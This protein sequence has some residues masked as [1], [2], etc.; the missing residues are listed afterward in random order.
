MVMMGFPPLRHFMPDLFYKG[1]ALKKAV[2]LAIDKNSV[3][4]HVQEGNANYVLNI[5]A[6]EYQ[7]Y[8]AKAKAREE[9]V[10]NPLKPRFETMSSLWRLT[11]TSDR[12]VIF[13]GYVQGRGV[14]KRD[15]V[16]DLIQNGL[17]AITGQSK[18]PASP[19]SV[20]DPAACN[21]PGIEPWTDK[22]SQNWSRLLSGM[23]FDEVE[24]IIGPVR[25]SGAILSYVT[26]KTKSYYSATLLDREHSH[27]HASGRPAAPVGGNVFTQSIKES[28]KN[29]GANDKL[30]YLTLQVLGNYIVGIGSST[31]PS[32][33]DYQDFK[34]YFPLSPGSPRRT[35]ISWHW[36]D[37]AYEELYRVQ[38]FECISGRYTLEFIDRKLAHWEQY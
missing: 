4:S 2:E 29:A 20:D 31:K 19:L 7:T 13:C 3:F 18:P 12:K 21:R 28:M 8:P 9:S 24:S 23:T 27:R 5:W 17:T 14:T 15:V 22:V 26:I 16:R 10:Y 11:R 36:L 35:I 30:E 37:K 34:H 33:R 25:T 32:I 38:D 6:D 1:S